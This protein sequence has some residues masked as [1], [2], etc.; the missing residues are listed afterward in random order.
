PAPPETARP[1]P[2]R[3]WKWLILLV[4]IAAAGYGLY[5]WL[6]RPTTHQQTAAVPAVRTAKVTT[7]TLERVARLAGQTS[8]RDFA[9]IT[10]PILR[11][12]EMRGN[13]VILKIV[14]SGSYVKK[15]DVV[16]E[17]D[18]QSVQDHLDDVNDTVTAAESDV[19][20]R[21]AEQQIEWDA[22][23]QTLRVAKAEWDKARL[24]YQAA[25]VRT[26]IERQLLKL[27]LDEAEA[28]YKQAQNDLSFK[29]QAHAAD[30]RILELTRERHIRHR[31]RH[32]GD[33]KR[34]TIRA[35]MAGLAVMQTVFRGGEMLQIQQGDQVFPGQQ[36]MKIVQPNSMQVEAAINQAESSQ[37]RIGQHARITLDGF[38]GVEVPG[39]IYAIGALATRSWRDQYY[40]RN[41]PVRFT[42]ATQ[43]NRIIP[44]LSASATVIL[45]KIENATLVPLGAVRD[46]NGR[47]VA[48]VKAGEAFEARPIRLGLR[49]DT[50]AAVVSGLR[51][52]DEVRLN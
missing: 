13:L 27:S 10:A 30:L 44:D 38:P 43:D 20:K 6:A 41:L 19:S 46:E 14:P 2:R 29:K 22:L 35:P 1:S 21:R 50:H 9:N 37:F 51:A 52:G 32:V 5:R 23:Q 39:R 33:L 4:V 11:G 36:I 31:D 28:R 45:D 40:I 49:N 34:F 7:G 3:P 42:L 15:G 24:D 25:E 47:T 48:W 12:P 26:D 17:L 16:L 18:A 8:A